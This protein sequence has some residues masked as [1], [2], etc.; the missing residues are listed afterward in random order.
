MAFC[1]LDVLFATLG[2]RGHI[3]RFDNDPPWTGP[4]A[5]NNGA[6]GRVVAAFLATAF[7]L[8]VVLWIAVWLTLKLL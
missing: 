2:I 6:I 8:A 4:L 7:F 1:V 3:P 5:T